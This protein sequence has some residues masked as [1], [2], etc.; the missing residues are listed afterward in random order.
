LRS[1]RCDVFNLSLW[2]IENIFHTFA[3]HHYC[4]TRLLDWTTSCLVAL[5]FAT[6][7]AAHTDVDAV[8]WCVQPHEINHSSAVGAKL[9]KTMWLPSID[10]LSQT[11]STIGGA[12]L[13]REIS[14]FEGP[15]YKL[16]NMGEKEDPFA[17]FFEAPSMD[18]VNCP[19]LLKSFVSNWLI[20]LAAHRRPVWSVQHG[21]RRRHPNRQNFNLKPSIRAPY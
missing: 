12:E 9:S 7:E 20:N 15:L 17:I 4:P 16:Q 8:V 19:L 11:I 5:H 18:K 6:M 2:L 1:C 10:D 21:V 13:P 14:Q 3:Q